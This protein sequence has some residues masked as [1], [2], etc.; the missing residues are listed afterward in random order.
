MKASL[1]WL[2]AMV[3]VGAVAGCGASTTAQ[4][5]GPARA[6]L[7]S[8]LQD[9]SQLVASP[10]VLLD[11]A[12]ALGV[13]VLRSNLLW[14]RIA[15]DPQSPSRP[16][17]D[18]S[19]PAAYPA[20]NWAPYDE[21]VRAAAALGIR[22][23][24]TLTGP[25]PLWAA[26]PGM[27]HTPSCRPCEQWMPSA[28]EF[29]Q[30][31]RAAGRRYSGSYTPAGAT[32]PL[33]RVSWWSIWNEP[34]YG[35]N[36]APQALHGSGPEVSPRLY[37]GLLDAA[38]SALGQTG[39][40]T[41]KD[42]IL[43]GETAPRGLT[44]H[45]YPGNTSGMVP[46]RF[47]RALYCVNG[48]FTP[49]RGVAAVQRGCPATQAGS[50][51]FRAE[52]P[53][54]FDATAWAA[55]LY[56]DSFPPDYVTPYDAC[57][58]PDYADFAVV[59]R[60]ERTLD[61]VMAAYGSNVQLPIYSTEFGY[62]TDPPYP[63]GVSFTLAARYMNQAE[64]LTWHNPRIRSYD[65]YLLLDPAPSTGSMF[66]TGLKFWNG[67]RKPYVYDAFRMPLFLP[68]ASAS[69]GQKLEVWGCARPAPS[70]QERTGRVQHVAVQ[71]AA[72]SQPFRTLRTVALARGGGCYLDVWVQFPHTGSVRLAW[73]GPSGWIYSRAQ[74]VRIS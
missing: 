12:K 65:Q 5:T 1:A 22:V 37:R 72:A 8:I 29:G 47:V 10:P 71:F 61:R 54:L 63:G 50:A 26:G 14:N 32:S 40:S 30:F 59:G 68:V 33:P 49:L 34:N 53:G 39:H 44:G 25:P 74:S 43:I 56:P 55:H 73:H 57:C 46:L 64:Y 45:R 28:S 27:P 18:A 42:T 24:F 52:N 13:Q 48:S 31:V 17:F 41:A 9:D 35:P 38:W 3:A 20:S 15:P 11:Q 69:S 4:P 21:T 51:T 62:K 16:Q 36:L 6:D 66:D 60:L 58:Q 7:M 19:D 67:Q 2:G 70:V 23:Y